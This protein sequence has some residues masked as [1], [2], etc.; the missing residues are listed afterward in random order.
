MKLQEQPGYYGNE[1][2]KTVLYINSTKIVC[3]RLY[4]VRL[5]ALNER[6][7]VIHPFA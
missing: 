5:D 6:A 1:K 7:W 4:A 3:F 2:I